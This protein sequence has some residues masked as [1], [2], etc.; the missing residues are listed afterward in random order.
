MDIESIMLSQAWWLLGPSTLNRDARYT[1]AQDDKDNPY[2]TP[3]VLDFSLL[4]GE[5]EVMWEGPPL[6]TREP[7]DG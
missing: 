4:D 3:F 2:G 5:D 1:P 6:P 7:D